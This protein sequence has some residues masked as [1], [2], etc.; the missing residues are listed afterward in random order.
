MQ[1][2]YCT[3]QNSYLDGRRPKFEV[4]LLLPPLPL[5]L[6][7]LLQLLLLLRRC[8]C[9]PLMRASCQSALGGPFS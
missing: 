3:S 7:L 9:C 1:L 6:L 5:L 2:A 8:F 4:R